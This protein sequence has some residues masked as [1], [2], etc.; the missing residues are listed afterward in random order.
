MAASTIGPA[1]LD[2]FS[3]TPDR[4]PEETR[5]PV[6]EAPAS[7]HTPLPESPPLPEGLG[8]KVDT[9]A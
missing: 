9:S 2:P 4:A 5:D 3:P 8:T 1:V 6:Q 7:E